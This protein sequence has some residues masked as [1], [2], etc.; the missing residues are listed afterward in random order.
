[1]ADKN[2]PYSI[3]A[4]KSIKDAFG[5][6]QSRFTGLTG[7]EAALRASKFGKNELQG[8]KYRLFFIFLRQ[9]RSSFTYLLAFA[10]L[11]AFLL[12]EYVDMIMIIVF[13]AIN[14]SL[15]F[16]EEYKSEKAVQLLKQYIKARARVRREGKEIIID[17]RDLVPGDIAI[18]EAGDI[19]QADI[20]IIVDNDLTAD[21]GTLTGESIPIRKSKQAVRSKEMDIFNAGS[22]GFAGTKIVGGRGEG[23]VIATGK[24]TVVGRLAAITE[25]VRREST[26]EKGL[27]KFSKFILYL[28]VVTIIL[29]FISNLIIKGGRL[30]IFELALFAIALAVSVIPEALPVVTSVSL[31]QGAIK[32][33]K[34]Q[35]VVRRLSAIED[36]GSIEV[37]CTDKTGTITENKLRVSD[38]KAADKKACLKSAALGSSF[39]NEKEEEPNNAFDIAIWNVLSENE[40]GSISS[41]RRLVELP[42]TPE[43]KRNSV[44]VESD[45]I[46]KMVSRGAPEDI[47]VLCNGITGRKKAEILAWMS[48]R[49]AEGKRTLAIAEKV[50]AGKIG[51]YSE[52]DEQGLV[53]L[54]IIA[55]E[56][57]IKD[58][59]I[60]AIA[61]AKALGIQ[62]K[63]I[64][65]DAREVAGA[66]GLQIGLIKN[67]EDV[68]TGSELSALS[69]TEKRD[70][71]QAYN[72]F[73]RIAP[74]QKYD[75]IRMLQEKHE[76]GYLGEGINDAPALKLANVSIVVASASDIAR[77][78]A[79]IVLT[80]KSLDVIVSGIKLG[81]E[82]FSNTVKYIKAT[83]ASNFGNFYAIAVATLMIDFLPMLPIQILLLNLLSDFPMI[84]I[85]TDNVDETEMKRP[86]SYDVKEIVLLA[87]ILGVVSTVFDF[88]FFSIFKS[89]G[90]QILHTYWFIASILTELILIFSIRTKLSMLKAKNPSFMLFTLSF[91][92]AAVTLAIPFLGIGQT[93]FGFIKPQAGY[94]ALIIFIVI[95][96]FVITEKVKLKYYSL[97]EGKNHANLT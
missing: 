42:F 94:L 91:I 61:D 14:V 38:I 9:F 81:R 83:L 44:I 63:I 48:A 56:D 21:E 97:T 32:L 79:D 5:E 13:L 4:A 57:P 28:V 37:L 78:A 27:N 26:F 75:I 7:E 41:H 68:I 51:S 23:I 84:A 74:E 45:G 89:G 64:T 8:K 33:A 35:V 66:V 1:M 31:S 73:A 36:L 16:F 43:R 71:L 59:T 24:N 85:A 50:L 6:L 17:A 19:V 39:L 18:V 77:E 34:K 29:I 40:T 65:G 93:L 69:P 87:T 22:I 92:A 82:I 90:P 72:V 20:R 54:G 2:A 96:Y 88:I 58:S 55:F 95:L 25:D 3:Y 67:A 10:I 46:K 86:R 80:Q 76:V 11:I 53:F 70:A 52:K 60:K 62:T 30:N 15:G 12:H 47:L 49:G